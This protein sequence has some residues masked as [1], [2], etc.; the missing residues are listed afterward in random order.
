MMSGYREARGVG[1][2]AFYLL[3][4]YMVLLHT[5]IIRSECVKTNMVNVSSCQVANAVLFRNL[6]SK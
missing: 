3:G 2:N 6:M 4:H 1:T 5:V